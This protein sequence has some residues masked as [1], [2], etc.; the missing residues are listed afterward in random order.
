MSNKELFTE[1]YK[2]ST[3]AAST[4]ERTAELREALP[5]LFQRLEIQSVLDCGC[6]DWN[7]MKTVFPISGIQYMG[8]DIVDE[9]ITKCQ[10]QFT[11]DSVNFQQL[12]CV[13]DPPEQ[14][15]LWL[16]RDFCSVLNFQDML[17]FFQKFLESKSKYIAITSIDTPKQNVD[18]I[19]G[20]IRPLNFRTAPFHMPEPIQTLPDG[21]QWFTRK[22]CLVYTRT[23]ILEW[24]VFT[25]SK[26]VIAQ[27]NMGNDILDRN[28]HL[29][30]NVRLRDVRIDDHMVSKK[31]SH[32]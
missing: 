14:A 20:N 4:L 28:A 5:E 29:V 8:V 23:Q 25:A 7:W 18:S 19:P 12:D 21:F 10:E 30:S 31:P 22:N 16:A 2:Q 11:A 27:Q 15:D 6:G 1:L 24:F 17:N 13:R 32:V 26:L 9:C 3:C